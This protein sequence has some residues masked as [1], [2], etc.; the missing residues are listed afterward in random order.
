MPFWKLSLIIPVI[1]EP[2]YIIYNNKD[3]ALVV[4]A[5]TEEEARRIAE[6]YDAQNSRLIRG[7]KWDGHPWLSKEMCLVEKIG[8]AEY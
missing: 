7:M 3:L 8:L 5:S 2:S 1:G 4:E 6:Q